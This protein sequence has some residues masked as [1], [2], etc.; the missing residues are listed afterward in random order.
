[1]DLVRTH[2]QTRDVT[3][4]PSVARQ[5]WVHCDIFTYSVQS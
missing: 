2:T 5:P 4:N 3:A 1:M